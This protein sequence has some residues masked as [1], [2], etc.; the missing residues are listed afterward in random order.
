M[1]CYWTPSP[2][3]QLSLLLVVASQRDQTS[4]RTGSSTAHGPLC[5]SGYFMGL[6]KGEQPSPPPGPQVHPLP[7]QQHFLAKLR[8]CSGVLP[9]ALRPASSG[10]KLCPAF[11]S[12][13]RCGGCVS[14]GPC[15]SMP[16][17]VLKAGS[18]P[19]KAGRSLE[20]QKNERGPGITASIQLL[21][22]APTL[23]AGGYPEGKKNL[24]T[25]PLK[26]SH[27]SNL[28]NMFTG[29]ILGPAHV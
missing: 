20:S 1:R 14:P 7:P 22:S 4:C 3:P 13:C 2:H 23:A 12:R 29:N 11:H 26:E 6:R 9:L 27:R 24:L 21:P 19:G 28:H 16:H 10:K 18:G 5:S 17:V 15:G 8:L 25:T